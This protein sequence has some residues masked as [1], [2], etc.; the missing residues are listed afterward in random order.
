[1]DT[2]AQLDQ[3]RHHFI[4][5]VGLLFEEVGMVRMAGR[6]LGHLLIC[7]PPHQSSAQ[8]AEALMASKGSISTNT[9]LLMQFGVIEKVRLPGHRGHYF[10]IRDGAWPQLIERELQFVRM[11]RQLADE[12]LELLADADATEPQRGRMRDFREVF[13]FF[14]REYPTIIEHWN[15][16]HDTEKP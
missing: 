12:G 1:M 13:A 5:Q 4:E 8:L 14:E 9:R 7:D 15:N 16:Q 6:I 2:A 3:R 10:R 11:V